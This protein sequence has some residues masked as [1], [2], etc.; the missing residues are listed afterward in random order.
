MKTNVRVSLALALA[1]LASEMFSSSSR[2]ALVFTD[3]FNRSTLNGGTYTYTTVVTAGDGAATVVGSDRLQLSNDS[4]AA[5]NANGR[6]YVTTATSAFGS[7][8][9]SQ[10]NQN[11][12]VVTWTLNM[13]QI[14]ADP[15]GFGGGGYGVAFV[16]GASSS[17]LTTA[18]G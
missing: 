9:N 11:P 3:N 16:L 4:T 15:S 6:V 12:G 7:P 18:N 5:A 14:R 2:A 10:L 17:D 1:V 13:Q 8:Y